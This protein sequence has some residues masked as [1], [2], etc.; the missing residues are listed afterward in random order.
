MA[1]APVTPHGAL[2]PRHPR[3]FAPLAGVRVLSLAL[4]LPGPAAL[5]RLR[6]LGAEVRK[7][8]PPGGDPMRA[9]CPTLYRAMHR[10]I[11][12]DTLDLKTQEGQQGL[13]AALDVSDVLLT[14][15]RPGALTRL[16]LDAATLKRGWPGLCVV[17]VVGAR[18]RAAA[19]AGHD[20]T[21]QAVAGLLDRATLPQTLVAD[22]L[23]AMLVVEAT[24]A[25]LLHARA[26]GKGAAL[27]VALA[28]AAAFA[29]APRLAGLTAPGAL[30]GGALAGYGVYRCSDG[31][32]AV[33]AL[34]P[35]F[36]A[37]LARAAGG[38]SRAAI[39]RWCRAHAASQLNAIAAAEDV[40]LHAWTTA[41]GD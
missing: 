1:S 20:L 27:Q 38:S 18:G 14:S 11:P 31:L 9:M 24:L 12:V 29:A 33:A 39:T 21:Y 25:A 19:H 32:V 3:G 15:F 5:T 34:E 10:G 40:P 26:T 37:A 22:M 36:A 30:L 28:D 13:H 6:A 2:V 41:R 8:E 23:G 35:H 16:G 7:V 17:S 4:N